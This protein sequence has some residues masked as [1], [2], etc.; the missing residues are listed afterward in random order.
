MLGR[1]FPGRAS[2]EHGSALQGGGVAAVPG[3][4]GEL[5]SA[6]AFPVEPQPSM[7]RLYRAFGIPGF[8]AD[9]APAKAR[10]TVVPSHARQGAHRRCIGQVIGFAAYAAPAK[11]RLTVVP[12]H[13]RQGP[14]R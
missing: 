1:G 8:A 14:Y 13:A 12:S 3:G 6:R 7:A 11:A 5:C 2:A 4:G 10:L 9:A